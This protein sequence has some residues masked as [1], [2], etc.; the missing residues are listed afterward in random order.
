MGDKTTNRT[1]RIVND[2][3]S[4]ILLA[5]SVQRRFNRLAELRASFSSARVKSDDHWIIVTI[6]IV[7][8]VCDIEFVR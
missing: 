6:A 8:V 3:R 5:A 1:L 7:V 2:S 4:I